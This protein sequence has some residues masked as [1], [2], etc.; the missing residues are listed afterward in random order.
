VRVLITGSKGFVGHWLAAHLQACGDEVFGVD[1]EVDIT[2]LS[3]LVDS[4][5]GWEPDW[6]CHLAAQASVGASWS[7]QA[8]TYE[9]NV[10]GTVNVLEAALA[11]RR[12][13]RVL[14]I[15]SSEVYGR[16]RPDQLPIAEDQPLAPINPYAAS[17][18]AAELVGRQAW[19]GSDLEVITARPFNHTGPGQRTD[20]VV[21][22]LAQQVAQ[23][24]QNGATS[25]RTGNLGARRDL[26]DVRDVVRAYRMMLLAGEPGEVY[27]VCRGES[28][29]IQSIA[30][31]LLELAG[32]AIPIEVD[33]ERVR[34][35]DIPDLRGDGTKL[36]RATGWSPEI[37]LDQTLRDILTYWRRPAE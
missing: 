6:I 29:S 30:E 7:G 23:A 22:A 10:I 15:S 1:T 8:R 32:V 17:K 37:D 26:S 3:P 34:P 16:V 9:V 24:A 13:P 2:L 21:P 31:R 27:N 35:V 4:V 5:T 12:R 28:Q 18:A 14:L 33:P 36:H 20:F 11:C 19:L 25:L